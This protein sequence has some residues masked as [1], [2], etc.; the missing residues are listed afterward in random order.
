M[1]TEEAEP[2]RVKKPWGEELI[3]AHAERYVGKVL[4]I[5]AGRR[6]SLQRHEIKD[7]SIYVMSG[8]L[9]LWLEND[10]GGVRGEELG[11]GEARRVRAGRG[12]RFGAVERCGLIGGSTPGLDDFLRPGGDFGAG[13]ASAPVPPPP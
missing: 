11:P 12:H 5:E 4:V 3:W 1:T 13:G 2:R 6:L 8:R 9:R 7:E 10:A